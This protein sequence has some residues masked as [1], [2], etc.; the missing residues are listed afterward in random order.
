MFILITFITHVGISFVLR[1]EFHSFP[2]NDTKVNQYSNAKHWILIGNLNQINELNMM[3]LK[4]IEWT[5]THLY[6]LHSQWGKLTYIHRWVLC[7]LIENKLLAAYLLSL[8]SICSHGFPQIFE[9]LLSVYLK[10]PLTKL[11]RVVLQQ[12]EGHKFNSIMC[13]L[14][15]YVFQ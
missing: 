7:K 6:I 14:C 11:H 13:V 9:M 15:K 10:N 8:I 2:L 5:E 1:R 4:S 12:N 3:N